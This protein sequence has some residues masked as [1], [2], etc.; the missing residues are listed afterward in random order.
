[1]PES[2]FIPVCFCGA[3]TN[4]L[5]AEPEGSTLLVPKP[6][7]EHAQPLTCHIMWIWQLHSRNHLY[8]WPGLPLCED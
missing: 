5:V 8:W 4:S 2:H 7:T 1:M 6:V 3:R